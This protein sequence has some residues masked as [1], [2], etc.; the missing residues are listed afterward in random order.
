MKKA[1]GLHKKFFDLM[2]FRVIIEKEKE[3]E[4]P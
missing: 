2:G 3:G 4:E 1:L